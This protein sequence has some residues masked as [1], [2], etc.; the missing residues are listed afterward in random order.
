MTSRQW[1]KI[2]RL[3]ITISLSSIVASVDL[4]G[5]KRLLPPSRFNYGAKARSLRR[6]QSRASNYTPEYANAP[7]AYIHRGRMG[8]WI[9]FI[10]YRLTRWGC[11]R[12]RFTLRRAH[13]SRCRSW[14]PVSHTTP[15]FSAEIAM[16]SFGWVFY[17]VLRD[18]N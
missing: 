10:V 6:K 1:R 17:C 9:Y 16:V 11:L 14:L 18:Q 8:I 3:A 13:F 2:D 15:W 4:T 7:G 12:W 5:H